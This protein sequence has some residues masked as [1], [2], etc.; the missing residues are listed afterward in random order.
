MHAA[1][2]S[3]TQVD[4]GSLLVFMLQEDESHAAYFLKTH[5]V[6]RLKLLRVISHGVQTRPGGVP[7]GGDPAAAPHRPIRSRPTPPTSS[8]GGGRARSIR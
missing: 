5:G 6:E 3:A 1:A 7:V 4:T 2:S 8:R